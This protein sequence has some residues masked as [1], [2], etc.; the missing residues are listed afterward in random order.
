[1]PLEVSQSGSSSSAPEG[2]KTSK[3]EEQGKKFGKKMGNAGMF[4][5]LSCRIY[6]CY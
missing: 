5:W 4:R 6:L 2:K 3:F 1:M